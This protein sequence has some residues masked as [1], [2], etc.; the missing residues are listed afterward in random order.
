MY[1][2]YISEEEFKSY[3]L[4]II[5]MIKEDSPREEVMNYLEE[6]IYE[7]IRCRQDSCA[8]LILDKPPG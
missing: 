3:L 1:N 2:G 5:E 7:R 8:N 6:L 4:R